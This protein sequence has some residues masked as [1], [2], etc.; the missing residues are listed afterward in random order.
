MLQINAQ[1]VFQINAQSVFQIDP[2]S[3]ASH[4]DFMKSYPTMTDTDLD[5][6]EFHEMKL[7][8]KRVMD[9]N[10]H[11]HITT[12]EEEDNPDISGPQEQEGD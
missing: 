9:E 7:K 3:P 8:C 4:H 5:H 11:I 1:S 6:C 12:F 10:E 2:L